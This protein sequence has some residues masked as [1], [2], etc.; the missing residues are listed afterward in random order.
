MDFDIEKSVGFLL[1]KAHQN[2]FAQFRDLLAPHGITPPQFALLGFLWKQDGLSQVELSEKTEIDRTTLSGLIDRLEKQG[3]VTRQ[4]H[5][6]D[7]R[8]FLVAL[9]SAGRAIESL[10]VPLAM[11]IRQQLKDGLSP[12]EYEQLCFLLNRLRGVRHD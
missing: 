7:R 9:T 1:A 5:P 4:P 8:A 3:L 6:G 2:L 11:Q 12:E 10:L